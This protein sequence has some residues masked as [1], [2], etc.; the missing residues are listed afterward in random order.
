MTED[1]PDRLLAELH[2]ARLLATRPA[3]R[4]AYAV[5]PADLWAELNRAPGSP[6]SLSIARTLRQDPQAAARYRRMLGFLAV[7]HSP[8][9]LAASDG[10]AE[11]RIGEA[12]LRLLP[13]VER[14]P[15]LL[16]IENTAAAALELVGA[17]G[18]VLRLTLPAADEGTVILALG[19]DF[20]DA[21]T[22][23]A[24]I[25]APDTALYLLP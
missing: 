9:A 23:V 14:T 12:M 4:Q 22:A 1:S 18:S 20:P 6:V 24:L 8:V 13:G 10:S 15:P 16:V 2:A 17:D 21:A 5:T 7:A 25:Q 19:V 3:A 11:R